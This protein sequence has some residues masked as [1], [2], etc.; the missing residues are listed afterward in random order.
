[1]GGTI[2]R[3]LSSFYYS[4]VEHSSQNGEQLLKK[5]KID[6]MELLQPL[7]EEKLITL[8]KEKQIPR[9]II[10]EISGD[11]ENNLLDGSTPLHIAAGMQNVKMLEDMIKA[12]LD[13][14]RMKTYESNKR[15]DSDDI[16][17]EVQRITWNTRN[18]KG[19][20]P[21]SIAVKNQATD[22]IQ[23]LID[24]GADPNEAYCDSGPDSER[25]WA[26]SHLRFSAWHGKLDSLR[27]LLTVRGIN[28]AWGRD[29]K[30]AIHLSVENDQL[31]AVKILLDDDLRKYYDMDGELSQKYE[32]DSKTLAIDRF[33]VRAPEVRLH[34]SAIQTSSNGSREERS[35]TT[36]AIDLLEL[37]RGALRPGA[38]E[39][40]PISTLQTIQERSTN[41][42]SHA[43]TSARDRGSSLIHLAA[44]YGKREILEF[45]LSH[46]ALSGSMH[47][48][49]EFGKEPIF[50]AVRNGHLK[51][52]EAFQEAGVDLHS[53][54]IENWSIMH[55][56]VKYQHLDILE[57]LIRHGADPN[58]SDDD[59]WTPLHVAARFSV[60]KAVGMLVEA[61]ANVNAGT[62]DN[63]S[64]LQITVSQ[65]NNEEMLAELLKYKPEFLSNIN[66]A[67][68]PERVMLDRKDFKMLK[69]YLD[70]VYEECKESDIALSELKRALVDNPMFLHRCIMSNETEIAR[71][72]LQLGANGSSVNQAGE[73]AICFAVKRGMTEM[74]SV[75][76]EFH[77][78][79]DVPNSDGTRP[80]HVACDFGY[81]AIVQ[82][83]LDHGSNPAIPVPSTASNV[84]FTP[85][86]LAARRGHTEVINLLHRIGADMNTQKED[87]YSALHLTAL[88]GHV[89]ALKALIKAEANTEISEQN[90][91]CPLHVAVRNQ[92]FEAST[93]LL[94]GGSDPG[95][96]GPSGLSALHFAAHVCDSRSIWL[97]IQCGI[98]PSIVDENDATALHY[99]S[100]QQRGQ[101]CIQLLL[102]CGAPI[103]ALDD[104][105]DTPLHCACQVGVAS[106]VRILLKRG[107]ASNIQNNNGETPLHIAVTKR[108]ESII[109]SLMKHGAKALETNE[110]GET[111]YDIAVRLGNKEAR[112]VIWRALGYSIDDTIPETVYSAPD[113]ITVSTGNLLDSQR[114]NGG[115]CVICQN[116]FKTGD[117]VRILPCGHQYHSSCI[118]TWFGGVNCETNDYCPLCQAS[119]LPNRLN[120]DSDST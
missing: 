3:D 71:R 34:S 54:D 50:M 78:N 32:N 44:S 106:N 21:L 9:N 120:D 19:L 36:A 39:D 113:N 42:E 40:A 79:P 28:S 17:H 99:C 18:K 87:G 55:E 49:N 65:R 20:S 53:S 117:M 98:R 109:T 95:A 112:L 116:E 81:T 66:S 90:G 108:S 23:L 6:P 14:V 8:E 27:A 107:A 60:P 96:V 12:I 70:Y 104:D 10:P 16:H 89:E 92:Q 93:A 7:T 68:S 111:P 56:S 64:V 47:N 67:L 33:V 43:V 100:R 118:I 83:L 84:G 97:L 5:W 114:S 4:K 72:L 80:I 102:T 101:S 61:G 110:K 51:C 11:E 22:S 26:W 75:L 105:G 74:V 35:S 103:N 25:P 1:M 37:L 31:E 15:N 13:C 2:S 76:L 58:A 30:R 24:V 63:E 119:V 29:G 77:T 46:P 57:Y 45:F 52:V 59:G 94:T 62:D 91:F 73:T 88:N 86:M 82:K 115:I 85:L 48:L 69:I 38:P 41:E